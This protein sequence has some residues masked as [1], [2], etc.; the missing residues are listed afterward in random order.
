MVEPSATPPSTSVAALCKPSTCAVTSVGTVGTGATD[1]PTSSNTIDSSRKPRPPPPCSSG[2]AMPVMPAVA[3]F[4]HS[5][6]SNTD[7][8]SFSSCWRCSCV[9]ASTRISRARARNDFWSS[10][11]E[12]S[13]SS[14]SQR[15]GHLEA[16][17][18]DEVSL[19][20]VGAAAE[21]ED[22]RAAVGAFD[23]SGENRPRRRALEDAGRAEHLE[24]QAVALAIGRRAVDLDAGGVRDVDLAD[25]VLPDVLPVEQPQRLEPRMHLRE[26]RLHPLLVDHPAVVRE[27]RLLRPTSRLEIVALED[28][29]RRQRDPLVVELRRDDRPAAVDLTNRVRNRH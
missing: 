21:G 13:M 24:E 1:R 29:R 26:V 25:A 19:D 16:E 23:P 17:D 28:R 14:L 5:G 11:S 3:S 7:Q 8:L 22:Q 20:L 27:L 15:S 2:T 10:V 12:K 4:C 18:G 9:A 6:R